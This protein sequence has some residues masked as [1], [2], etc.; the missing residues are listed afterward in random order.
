MDKASGVQGT[1]QIGVLR[2]ISLGLDTIR[3][4]I[5]TTGWLIRALDNETG[6]ITAAHLCAEW[7]VD[8]P[9]A[10]PAAVITP[11]GAP[12]GPPATGKPPGPATGSQGT[13]GEEETD[14]GSQAEAASTEEASTD[15]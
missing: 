11:P 14:L 15:P 12:D 8:V 9:A 4:S 1:N 2:T 7:R 10:A 5:P 13:D 6:R 3:A